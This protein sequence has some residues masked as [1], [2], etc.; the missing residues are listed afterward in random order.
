MCQLKDYKRNI[1]LHV[2]QYLEVASPSSLIMRVFTLHSFFLFMNYLVSKLT[3]GCVT[4][5]MSGH[6]SAHVMNFDTKI[7]N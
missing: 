4:V 6:Y 1:V 3:L 5:N 7:Q 2:V